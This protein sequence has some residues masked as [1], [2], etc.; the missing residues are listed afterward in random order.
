MKRRPYRLKDIRDQRFGRLFVLHYAG[1]RKRRAYWGT[2]CDCGTLKTV[3]GDD[4]IQENTRSCGCLRR[5]LARTQHATHGLSKHPLYKVWKGM[6]ERC[7]YSKHKAYDRYHGR[8]IKVCR[9]WQKFENFYIDMSPTY[10][11]GLLLERLNNAKGYS[12]YNCKW[13]PRSEQ[14]RNT[15]RNR[16]INTPQGKMLLCAAAEASG[17]ARQVIEKRIARGWKTSQLFNPARP[18]SDKR[19]AIMP[20]G[21]L[22][23]ALKR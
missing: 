11:P 8:G 16:T 4:L 17:L 15:R 12:A 19:P 6:R 20:I 2:R 18:M 21:A 22:A 5:E 10:E 3:A 14:M 1:M 13:A 23:Q 9:R 7:N